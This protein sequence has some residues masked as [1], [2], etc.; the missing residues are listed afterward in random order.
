MSRKRFYISILASEVI[1]SLAAGLATGIHLCELLKRSLW[2][3]ALGVV[4]GIVA[5]PLAGRWIFKMD[6]FLS[7]W[8]I[9]AGE[10]DDPQDTMISGAAA[11]AIPV[12]ALF[13]LLY[14][15]C[16][17]FIE[18]GYIMRGRISDDNLLTLASTDEYN[19]K[20]VARKYH[21][22]MDGTEL[23]GISKAAVNRLRSP[24]KIREAAV[25]LGIGYRP[26]QGD[27]K[28]EAFIRAIS[29]LDEMDRQDHLARVY[30]GLWE[31]GKD[32]GIGPPIGAMLRIVEIS[33]DKKFLESIVSD[34]TTPPEVRASAQKRLA[35]L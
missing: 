30:Y 10:T 27:G 7:G 11:A 26:I 1:L 34:I 9:D 17:P 29:R 19:Y 18:P 32:R 31:Y 24:D 14:A 13:M 25:A 28:S 12:F 4:L 21:Y 3:L 35:R 16:C 6:R 15:S 8:G 2:G 23:D 20:E 33:R 22:S 5:A